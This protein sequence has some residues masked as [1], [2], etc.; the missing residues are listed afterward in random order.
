MDS[1]ERLRPY[2]AVMEKNPRPSV[3]LAIV[4]APEC[5]PLTLAGLVETFGAAGVAW[6]ELTGQPSDCPRFDVRL[7]AAT[8]DV[9][10]VG[11]GT[12]VTPHA[13]FAD[14]GRYDIVL[15]PDL[16][17][18]NQA[19]PRGRWPEAAAFLRAQYAAG[20]F[21]CSVCSGAVLLADAGLLDGFAA[22]T[23][24]GYADLFARYFPTVRLRI[25]RILCAAAPGTRLV[26]AGGAAAWEELAL[27]LVAHFCGPEEAVRLRK[28]FLFGDRSDGQLPFAALLPPPDHADP[29]I[30]LAQEWAAENYAEHQPV[31][32]MAAVAGLPARTFA[33]RFRKAT[34]YAPLEYIQT[35]RVEEAKQLL[36]RTDRPAEEVACLVGYD[37][38]T[39]FRRI[40]RKRVGETPG[41]YR[42]RYRAVPA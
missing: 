32:G 20:S 14:G 16:A 39:H 25:E 35:L 24:W 36:E 15:V 4:A 38:P 21:V 2:F 40:F 10:A 11:V 23:H 18:S 3:R 1:D 7:V 22:T 27:W 26:T 5:A 6:Q 12:R 28:V 37:D 29:A 31:A 17:I 41:A 19:D 34:G 8:P 30:R 33:R 42:R 13:T 9:L